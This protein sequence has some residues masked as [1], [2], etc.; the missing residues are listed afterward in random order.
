MIKEFEIKLSPE[1]RSQLLRIPPLPTHPGGTPRRAARV[2]LTNGIIQERAIFL[3]LSSTQINWMVQSYDFSPLQRLILPPPPPPPQKISSSEI[4]TIE[5][6]DLS[7]PC[8]IIQKLN[9]F[10]ETGMGYNI[11]ELK[12]HEDAWIRC[13]TQGEFAFLHLPEGITPS[14]L[15]DVR[16][17]DRSMENVVAG[18]ADR[19]VYYITTANETGT[20]E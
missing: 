10:D 2:V 15:V 16:P 9:S 13:F 14:M 4:K 3:Q 5:P 20:G 18:E 7:T 17:G 12:I 11:F 19:V 6:T 1:L 8:H